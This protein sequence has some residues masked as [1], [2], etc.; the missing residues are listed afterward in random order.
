MSEQVSF[1][2]SSIKTGLHVLV[3][4]VLAMAA[5]AMAFLMAPS[6]APWETLLAV[7]LAGAA[8]CLWSHFGR[9]WASL[10]GC[11]LLLWPLAAL[12]IWRLFAAAAN[13]VPDLDAA[14]VLETLPGGLA[15]RIEI[16]AGLFEAVAVCWL[17]SWL[18]QGLRTYF[19]TVD[20]FELC[21]G[22][23]LTGLLTVLLFGVYRLSDGYWASVDVI[24]SIDSGLVSENMLPDPTY[25]DL[26][27]PLYSF[28]F[29]PL[30][31]WLGDLASLTP[32]P[33]FAHHLLWGLMGAWMLV[34]VAL[35][36]YRLS[37]RRRH[38]AFVYMATMPVGLFCFF[39]EKYQ[40]SVFFLVLAVAALVRA[41]ARR[42]SGWGLAATGCMASSAPLLLAVL[43]T[44]SPRELVKRLG[45]LLCAGLGLLA[46]S[47]R[48]HVL[49]HL[50]DHWQDVHQF[51]E[52]AL[53][54]R[55]RI[56]CYFN[57]VYACFFPLAHRLYEDRLYWRSVGLDLRPLG[58]VI[59]VLALVGFV[60]HRR[61]RIYQLFFAWLVFQP[62][63]TVVFAWSP[64]ESPLFSLYFSWAV[65]PLF[66][67]GLY[68]ILSRFPR[69]LVLGM[70][71]L[72]GA[73]LLLNG[74]QG[75]YILSLLV[76]LYPA[77]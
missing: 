52:I 71:L 61:E 32:A 9:L 24:F 29:W 18:W 39:V 66:C 2:T 62:L 64:L 41:D 25:A 38:V 54:V 30:H 19:A 12:L 35:L 75:M 42:A 74:A 56:V 58:V 6:Q 10:A 48:L 69:L 59:L 14:A 20:L 36:L 33:A 7:I 50:A 68:G 46:V 76:R 4:L 15:A 45:A 23:V 1:V 43:V 73:L 11:P 70:G 47:G 60:L 55:E 37:G 27:H 3:S 72:C 49:L 51:T 5:G 77:A 67:A 13:V 8:A 31:V 63:F 16:L 17:L 21:F 53:S 65:V 28:F 44:R 34:G 40:P 26:R 57:G 22:G